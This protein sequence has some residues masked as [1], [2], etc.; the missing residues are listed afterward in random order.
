[1]VNA[2]DGEGCRYWRLIL[3]SI[4]VR[5]PSSAPILMVVLAQLVE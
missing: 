3:D 4:R 2:E 5:L 1:M